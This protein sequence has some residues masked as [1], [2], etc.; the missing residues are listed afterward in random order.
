MRLSEELMFAMCALISVRQSL[1]RNQRIF[2]VHCRQSRRSGSINSSTDWRCNALILSPSLKNGSVATLSLLFATMIAKSDCRQALQLTLLITD[3]SR[4]RRR[5]LV[6]YL[7][8]LAC[9]EAFCRQPSKPAVIANRGC[10]ATR[11]DL[12]RA[13]ILI[14]QASDYYCSSNCLRRTSI[15]KTYHHRFNAQYGFLSGE[16][17]QR[18]PHTFATTVGDRGVSCRDARHQPQ[19]ESPDVGDRRAPGGGRSR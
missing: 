8:L 3:P 13:L 12:G 19:S 6:L 17:V 1:R 2:A 10:K 18:V 16:V 7:L 15:V 4:P 14:T 11:F 5:Y 9:V